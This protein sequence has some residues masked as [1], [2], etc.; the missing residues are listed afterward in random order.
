L[1]GFVAAVVIAWTLIV[2]C[3]GITPAEYAILVANT[4]VVSLFMVVVGVYFSLYCSTATRAMTL[5]VLAWLGAAVSSSVIVALV[6]AVISLV[7]VLF[8][9]YSTARA[10]SMTGT[11]AAGPPVALLWQVGYV[12]GSLMLYLATSLWL[13]RHCRRHFDRLAGRSYPMSAAENAARKA[14]SENVSGRQ[15]ERSDIPAPATT[16]ELAQRS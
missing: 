9:M 14:F 2:I 10:G 13:I 12:V 8:W 6:L 4:L 16:P 11:A 1:R 3:G 15:R 7:I 5:T